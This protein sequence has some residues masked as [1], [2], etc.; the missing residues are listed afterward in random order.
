CSHKSPMQ[1]YHQFSPTACRLPLPGLRDA[2]LRPSR[3]EPGCN[4]TIRRAQGVLTP[5][6]KVSSH[7][8]ERY[9]PGKAMAIRRNPPTGGPSS[10]SHTRGLPTDAAWTPGH[11]HRTALSSVPTA[12]VCSL[13]WPTPLGREGSTSVGPAPPKTPTSSARQTPP[14]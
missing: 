14:T 9:H 2:F 10:S 6:D 13:V 7:S 4:T 8:I 12:D 5:H 3:S 11:N 1:P